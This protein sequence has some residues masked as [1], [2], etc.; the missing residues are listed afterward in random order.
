MTSTTD[1]ELTITRLIPL[2]R[3]AL[4]RCWTE[5]E[6]IMQWFTPKPWKTVGA[7][8]DLRPGGSSVI[9]MESP[10]GQQFPN[11]G[12]YLD[13]VDQE[14]LVFTDAFVS[15]WEPSEKPFMVGTITFADEAGGTRYTA[16]VRHWSVE[17]RDRHEAMGF[18]EGWG[19]ATDQLVELA[20]TLTD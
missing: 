8:T 18:H 16:V 4:W 13:V 5:P 6:L 20:A 9:T 1:R 7:E 12:V 15:A 19:K 14:R 17:D 2:P 10:E 11:R 3:R